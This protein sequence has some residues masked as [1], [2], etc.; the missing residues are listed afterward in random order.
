MLADEAHHL[1]IWS[2]AEVTIRG[3][4]LEDGVVKAEALDDSRRAQVEELANLCCYLAIAELW[5]ISPQN[6]LMNCAS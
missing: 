6:K 1:G 3:C 2:A 5:Q 4:S